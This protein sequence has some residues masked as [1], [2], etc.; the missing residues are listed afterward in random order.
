LRDFVRRVKVRGLRCP[1]DVISADRQLAVRGSVKLLAEHVGRLR[2]LPAHGNRKLH[3]DQLLIALLLSFFDPTVRSLR[4]IEAEEN[5]DGRID[6]PRLARS[7]TSDALR[8]MDPSCLNPIIRDLKQRV[9]EL[10]H[11]DPDLHGI[12]QRIIAADGT[13][14][15]VFC[16]AA[17]AL[18][19]TKTNGKRQGQVRAN[20][21]LD[22]S[23][24]TPQ[25]LTISGDDSESE[26]AAFAK[27]LLA[28]VLYVVDRNFLDFT[29]ISQVLDKDSDLVLRVRVNAPKT[30][31][32]Q[33]RSLC[34]KD[35]EAGV[36]S[37]ELVELVGRDAPKQNFRR[38]VIHAVNR[39]GET[40][41]IRLLTSLDE[42]VQA[43][44]IAAIYRQRWQ[45]ELFFKWLKTWARLDHLLSTSRNGITF[46]LYVAVIAVLMMQVQTGKRV[47]IY[48]LAA[49]KRVANGQITLAGALRIIAR[50]ERERELNRLR[51]ARKRAQKKLA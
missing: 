14:F 42:D 28:G 6:L 38:V 15:T 36:V 45:I 34:A 13:Y 43:Y 48:T 24:W 9:P 39:A 49:L 4:L 23:T 21:Q 10:A 31:T 50:F 11:A 19:H 47:S 26:P 12:V 7:T 40:E 18:H 27:D 1:G 8:M 33:Q 51:Q 44:V 2:E 3:A 35:I 16:D 22:V 37:D 25:V 32:L 30:R 17:W 29:F 5:F 41:T 46:Q 20:V